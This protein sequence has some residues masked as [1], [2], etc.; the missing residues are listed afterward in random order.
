MLRG[1]I[2]ADRQGDDCAFAAQADEIPAIG[3]EI[4]TAG[5]QAFNA[6]SIANDAPMR[7]NR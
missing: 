5:I 3:A 6:T 1:S 7:G 4:A 2:E